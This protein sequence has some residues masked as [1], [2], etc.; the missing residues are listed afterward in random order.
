MQLVVFALRH[1]AQCGVPHERLVELTGW[2]NPLVDEALARSPDPRFIA[3][4]APAVLDA[5]A[6]A[7]AA[8]GIEATTRLQA[9]M[10]RILADV[11]DEAG[12]RRPTISPTCTSAWTPNGARGA[13]RSDD[14]SRD[15]AQRG[16][17]SRAE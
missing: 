15:R 12:R 3:R 1:A 16:A 8:A 10:Q 6:V 2:D 7:R 14:R 13:R 11:G 17:R 9:L 4:I 5:D